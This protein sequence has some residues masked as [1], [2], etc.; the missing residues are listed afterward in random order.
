MP[1][2]IGVLIIAVLISISS[3]ADELAI[4]SGG[5]R[6]VDRD[7]STALSNCLGWTYG[8]SPLLDDAG[9]VVA[10]YTVSDALSHHCDVGIESAQ[11]FGDTIQRHDVDATGSWTTGADVIARA[12][13][14]WMRDPAF[15]ADHPE[16]F[17]GHLSSPSVIRADGRYYMA[18]VGSVDDRN[19]CA[20]EH[21]TNNRCGSCSDPWSYF[22]AMW[23][24]SD[25]GVNWRIRERGLGDAT[26]IGRAPDDADRAPGSQFKGVTHVMLVEHEDAGR[27]YFY[28]GAQYW[29]RGFIKVLMFRIERDPS[30]E[31]GIAGAPQVWSS[32]RHAWIDC[33]DGRIPDFFSEREEYGLQAFQSAPSSITPTTMFGEPMFIA[34]ASADT[35]YTINIRG[36]ANAVMYYLSRDLVD[37]TSG[38]RL[39]SAVRDVADGFGYDASVIDPIAIDGPDHSLRLFFASADGDPDHGIERD[40]RYDCY[41]DP[42]I[43]VTAPYVGTG[44]Y[45]SQVQ[46]TSLQPTTVT[47]DPER[48]EVVAGSSVRFKV[49]VKAADGSTPE[50]V[51]TIVVAGSG[52]TDRRVEN[53]E[54][55]FDMTMGAPAQERI[56][57]ASFYSYGVWQLGYSDIVKLH[58]VAAPRRRAARH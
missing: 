28:I 25:D 7:P 29:S 18:F 13:F 32:N 42:N 12:S 39:R 41:L 52:F 55:T 34:L 9:N 50:G 3:F 37:W 8:P 23:A 47:V 43:G 30:S 1:A 6:I 14:S 2:R 46:W 45:E 4:V 54:A 56:V 26:L 31:W 22:T 11:R 38:Y 53:G 44:I 48:L 15:L 21:A 40:G 20:A 58:V 19:L 51:V 5:R 49:R 17:I 16:T 36:R 35:A 27:Q 57:Y 24:V 33:E 10:M